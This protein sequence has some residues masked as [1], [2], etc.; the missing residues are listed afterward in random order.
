ML[1]VQDIHQVIGRRELDFEG[2]YRETI[3]P[4][5]QTDGGMSLPFFAWCPH[6]SGEG[7]EA[8]TLTALADGEALDRYQER[9]RFGDLGEICT[10]S[11]AMRYSLHSSVHVLQDAAAGWE[12]RVSSQAG[13]ATALYRL[14]V[15]ELSA[16]ARS[17]AAELN[18][19]VGHHDDS[20]VLS[21]LCWW[22][23]LFGDGS[24]RSVAVLCRVT[25]DDA[26]KSAFSPERAAQSWGRAAEDVIGNVVN[27]VHRRLLRSPGWGAP[28]SV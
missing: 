18:N 25:S 7:Y 13:I 8:V 5:L 22:S 9:I 17:V 1:I 24:D 12:E 20:H 23:P 26:L 14:D 28:Q 16:P 19:M 11:E 3:E 10:Q 2:L 27:R 4:A 15:L 6:G 21:P